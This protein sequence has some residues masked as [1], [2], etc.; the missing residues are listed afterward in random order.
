VL[1]I[2]KKPPTKLDV[3]VTDGWTRI[4]YN[5]LRSLARRGLK[6]GL[7]VDAYSGMGVYSRYNSMTFSYPPFQ[8]E[9]KRF[10]ASVK[11]TL[12][13]YKP[14]V[15]I[16]SEEDIFVVAKHRAALKSVPVKIPI[17][18]IE[19][20]DKLNN[21]NKATKLAQSL[22][23]PVPATIEPRDAKEIEAFSRE[24]GTPVVLKVK[25]SSTAR[26]VFY[27]QKDS[28]LSSLQNIMEHNEINFGDFIIQQ[29]VHGTGYGVS[30]LFDNGSLRAKFTHRRLRERF[31]A[32]GPSTL[33]ES[34]KNPVLEDW[35]EQ[36]LK[37][38]RFHGVAMIEFKFDEQSQKGWFIEANPRFWGSLALAIRAGV[39]FPYL[40]YKMAADGN[41]PAVLDYQTGIKVRWLLGDILTLKDICKTMKRIP[42]AKDIFHKVNGYDDFYV[43]DPIPFFASIFLGF[44]KMRKRNVM[45]K[46]Q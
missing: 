31:L 24:Y 41:I 10:I 16:P 12:L 30:M 4:S 44:R 26:G 20:I 22:D 5:I 23:I 13:K 1:K 32:G 27:L 11:Q 37:S 38:V 34:V 15:Y 40:L 42:R 45:T 46:G 18:S 7:G 25:Y 19:T 6:V 43:D 36:L 3:I 2:L 14:S 39:D 17:A 33:R 28:L 8:T 21:K 29:F 9:E 35:A